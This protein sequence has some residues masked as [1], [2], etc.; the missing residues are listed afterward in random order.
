MSNTV[1]LSK[2]E[3][4]WTDITKSTLPHGEGWSLAQT[5]YQT[6]GIIQFMMWS[7]MQMSNKVSYDFTLDSC[8]AVDAP[9]GTDPETLIEQ[10]KAKFVQRILDNDVEINFENIFD[11]ETGAYDEDWE[12]YSRETSK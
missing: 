1:T 2:H 12:T 9:I 6:T 7:R 5:V 11:S 3:M 4:Q 10:A 8:V